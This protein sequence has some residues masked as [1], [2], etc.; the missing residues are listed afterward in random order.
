[1]SKKG[2]LLVKSKHEVIFMIGWLF[3]PMCSNNPILTHLSILTMEQNG[4]YHGK[5]S[6][7]FPNYMDNNT[8]FT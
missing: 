6:C 1:M 8:H 4:V 7:D 5:F 2:F 3:W